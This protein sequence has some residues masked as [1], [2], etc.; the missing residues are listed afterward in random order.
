[1]RAPPK[2]ALLAG[3]RTMPD[4]IELR[5]LRVLAYCGALPEEQVRRQP[6]SIDADI[7]ADLSPA[8][9]TD[10][11]ARTVDYGALCGQ[12]AAVANDQRFALMERFATVV[13][14]ELLRDERID[15]VTISVTKCRPPV[16][17]DLGSSGVRIQRRRT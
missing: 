8:G 15:G 12:I 16:P 9:S 7:E 14:E 1:M 4:R 2:Q 17:E 10:D 13:A 11:L 6:F 5:G 3:H